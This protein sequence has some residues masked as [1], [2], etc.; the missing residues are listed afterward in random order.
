MKPK[1]VEAPAAGEPFQAERTV[2]TLPLWLGDPFHTET[3][4]RD[5]LRGG[6]TLQR[7]TGAPVAVIV[8]LPLQP[9]FHCSDV[10]EAAVQATSGSPGF[11]SAARSAAEPSGRSAGTPFRCPRPPARWR[12]APTAR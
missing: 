2:I 8:P 5:D 6:V 9:P 10:V 3:T 7:E 11:V 4:C 12:R 1:L